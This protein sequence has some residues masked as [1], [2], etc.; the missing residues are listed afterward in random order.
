[1]DFAPGDSLLLFTDGATEIHNSPGQADLGTE[2]LM[3]VLAKI[4]FPASANLAAV[5]DELL[6]SSGRIRFNDDL[7]LLQVRRVE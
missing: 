2:G 3:K 5:E 1:M 7:T 4:G 6:T